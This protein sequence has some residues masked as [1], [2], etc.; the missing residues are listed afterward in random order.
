MIID[1]GQVDA[2]FGDHLATSGVMS[3]IATGPEAKQFE[4]AFDPRF[5]LPLAALRVTPATAHVTAAADRL[6]ARFGPWVCRTTPANV[7]AV[8]L[9][10]PYHWHRAVGPPL[11]LADHGLTFGSPPSAGFACCS[12]NRCAA[13]T[14]SA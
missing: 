9:T 5:R 7:R 3:S 6:V 13:S 14:R 8:R 1:V 10:G 2:G 4:M 11:S 12:G